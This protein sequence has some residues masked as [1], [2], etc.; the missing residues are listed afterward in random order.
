MTVSAFCSVSLHPPFVLVCVAHQAS[1]HDVLMAAPAFTINMLASTQESIARRFADEES[2]RFA[3]LGFKRGRY[4]AA[5]LNDVLAS[6][7]CR[8]VTRHTAG[9][10]TIVIGE[11]EIA[12]VHDGRPLLY[13]RGGFAQLER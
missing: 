9:D 4:G 3:S 10:H 13:Y 8:P 6:L 11:A 5:I 1:M 2:Q 12:A 7:E